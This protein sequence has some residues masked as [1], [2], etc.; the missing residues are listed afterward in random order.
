MSK[1][2]NKEEIIQRKK[3][4]IRKLNNLLESY[5]NDPSQKHLKKANLLSYWL[6]SYTDY[7]DQ[8]E[9]FD[10]KRLIS[11]K[12]GDI[13]KVNFGFNVGSE[14]G[15]LH[16]AVVLD[17]NNLQ[18]SP[19]VTVI[20]LSSGD[21]SSVYERDVYLGRELYSK[22]ID[23]HQT[24]FESAIKKND[25][26]QNMLTVLENANGTNINELIHDLQTQLDETTKTLNLLD[27][28]KREIE[29][30]KT[31]SIAMIEQI[32]TISKMRIYVPRKANDLLYNMSLSSNA[33][34]KINQQLCNLFIY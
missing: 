13:L 34:E 19:V 16:Y 9:S 12:R 24:L 27:K 25:S 18:S 11:Y 22:M 31:G 15:G 10:S 17:K 32:T 7:I 26:V 8:E 6:S 30:M 20:P 21:E 4:S 3:A 28:Y 14:H 1:E 2:L 29:N 33:M 23:K 5:I